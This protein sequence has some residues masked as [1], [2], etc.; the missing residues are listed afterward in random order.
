MIGWF[1]TQAAPYPLTQHEKSF[2]H[3]KT[4]LRHRN[5][6]ISKYKHK[7]NKDVYIFIYT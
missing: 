1:P 7:R 2:Y 5:M 3:I 6:G 4:P